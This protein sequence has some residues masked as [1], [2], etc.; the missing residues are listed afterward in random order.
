MSVT[1]LKNLQSWPLN[2]MLLEYSL[3]H[4]AASKNYL[5]AIRYLGKSPYITVK[6]EATCLHF[7]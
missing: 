5:P 2:Y 6:D 7:S 1:T 3:S 4:E